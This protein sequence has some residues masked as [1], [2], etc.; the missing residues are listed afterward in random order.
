LQSSSDTPFG[1]NSIVPLPALFIEPQHR[2]KA[3]QDALSGKKQWGKMETV[4]A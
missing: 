4:F 3:L 2:R 1:A